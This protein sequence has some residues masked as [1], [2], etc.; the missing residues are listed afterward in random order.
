MPASGWEELE[1][2]KA[3]L[4]NIEKAIIR[5]RRQKRQDEAAKKSGPA[6]EHVRPAAPTVNKRLYVAEQMVFVVMAI[7]VWA[8]A[9]YGSL[10]SVHFPFHRHRTEVRLG[11]S[12]PGF[13]LTV[14]VY[15]DTRRFLRQCDADDAEGDAEDPEDAEDAGNTGS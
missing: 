4:G 7:A 9:V 13:L 5:K 3:L 10:Y 1:R 2:Q 12:I 6:P 14:L 15:S 8:L 11:V